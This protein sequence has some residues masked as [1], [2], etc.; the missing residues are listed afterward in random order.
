M[1]VSASG[2]HKYNN[3]SNNNSVICT[4]ITIIITYSNGILHHYKDIATI[5]FL[6]KT[7]THF[8]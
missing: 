4:G 6:V 7:T 2:K 1:K 5:V 3:N 8:D